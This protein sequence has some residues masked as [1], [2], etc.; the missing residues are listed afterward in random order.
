MLPIEPDNAVIDPAL[1]YATVTSSFTVH[2]DHHSETIMGDVHFWFAKCY[3]EV[4][5]IPN[6]PM[7]FVRV[8]GIEHLRSLDSNASSWLYDEDGVCFPFTVGIEEKDLTNTY[9]Q[10][11]FNG[12]ALPAPVSSNV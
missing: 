8:G 12:V 10:V 2:N 9:N 4:M 6:T 1:D 11:P 3:N 7:V 5:S